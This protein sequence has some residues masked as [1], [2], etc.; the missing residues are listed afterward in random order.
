MALKSPQSLALTLKTQ[1][2]GGLES[3]HLSGHCLPFL[4]G[5][6]YGI[7]ILDFI[8]KHPNSRL[9]RKGIID[10][11]FALHMVFISFLP[12]HETVKTQ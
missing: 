8:H 6:C 3:T 10:I 4:T 11:D 2:G 7:K 9:I 5:S 12:I 1:G